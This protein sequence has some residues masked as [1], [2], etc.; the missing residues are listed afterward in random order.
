[1]IIV[2][3]S[4]FFNPVFV[5]GPD[6]SVPGPL[7]I[8][9]AMLH[10]DYKRISEIHKG[11]NGMK[12]VLVAYYS[13]TGNTEQMARYIAE[14]VRIAGHE[15]EAKSVAEIESEKDLLGYDG[16]IFGCPTYHLDIPEAFKNF[17]DLAGKVG[18]VGKIGGAF[19]C[20]THPSSSEGS[21]AGIIFHRM[22]SEFKM[23]MTN[24]GPFDLKP[25]WLNGNKSEL[26]GSVETIRTCQDYGRALAEMIG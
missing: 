8:V 11:D 2:T 5:K 26:A 17:L 3:D 25:D 4:G 16:Y 20:R 13:N 23:K 22:E 15:A 21:A 6:D 14:G 1:L 19:D 7:V 10:T 24:L 12:R 18:L 9:S